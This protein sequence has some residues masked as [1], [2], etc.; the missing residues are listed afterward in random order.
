LLQ[1]KGTKYGLSEL[2]LKRFPFELERNRMRKIFL[3][4]L[5]LILSCQSGYCDYPAVQVKVTASTPEIFV[6]QAISATVQVTNTGTVD[7]ELPR[8]DRA[9]FSALLNTDNPQLGFSGGVSIVS[10][11]GEAPTVSVKP[12]ESISTK[13]S[14]SGTTHDLSPI[15]FRIG[16]KP[17]ANSVPVWSNSVTVQFKKDE[18]FPVK[19]EASVKESKIDI[20][21]VQNPRSATAH[22]RITNT[23]N[24]SQNIGIAGVCCLHELQSLISDNQA[25]KIE[26]GDAAC[27]KTSCGPEEVTLKPGEIWEQDCR[28]AYWGEDPNPKPISFRIGVK[29]VGHIPAW[30]DPVTVNIVGGKDQWT[31]HIA[32]LNNSIKEQ[33]A[34]SHPDG[35]TKAYYESGALMDVATYKGGKLDGPYKR[36]YANGQLWQ[37]LNY[38]DNKQDGR[39]KEYNDDGK[40]RVESL[41][42][43]G[44]LVSYIAYNPDGTVYSHMR[45]M[46]E[47]NG[48]YIYSPCTEAD[49]HNTNVP[50]G[51][52]PK[53]N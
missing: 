14:L 29:S 37:E 12:G 48:N 1:G 16:F 6:G 28:L 50:P 44:A 32:Y 22:A 43:N 18:D 36:Y 34:T 42:H 41:Y 46:R 49:D 35:I 24:A 11:N 4:I 17:T 10:V 15:T 30:S 23:S 9:G 27:L 5:L 19:V 25:I 3:P 47:V 31:K 40:L 38:V 53:C 33:Q 21:D 51:F 39:K 13:V 52:S 7:L 20:S 26:S 45:Y 2:V 8:P